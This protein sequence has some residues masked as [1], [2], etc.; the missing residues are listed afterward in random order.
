MALVVTSLGALCDVELCQA[1]MFHCLAVSYFA[2]LCSRLVASLSLLGGS[3]ASGE[4]HDHSQ[5]SNPKPLLAV[6]WTAC[7]IPYASYKGI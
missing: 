5:Q 6:A 3:G 1:C 2:L 7:L 4:T